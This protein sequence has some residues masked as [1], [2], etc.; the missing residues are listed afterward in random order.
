MVTASAFRNRARP[1]FGRRVTDAVPLQA[2]SLADDIRL[3]ATFFVGGFTF[4]A[5]YLA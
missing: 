4:M 1:I 3:F 5:V 2:A